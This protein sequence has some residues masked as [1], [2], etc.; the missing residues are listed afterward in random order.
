M[1]CG[2][3][4]SGIRMDKKMALDREKVAEEVCQRWD[5]TGKW[6]RDYCEALWTLLRKL[7][8][9]FLR[10]KRRCRNILKRSLT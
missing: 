1:L 4:K 6:H 9:V 5:E 7:C 8:F 3:K 10:T 2:V